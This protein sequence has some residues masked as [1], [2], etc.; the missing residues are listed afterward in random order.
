MPV[1]DPQALIDDR[2][3][4]IRRFHEHVG[5]D[6]AELDLSGG[7]DSATMLGLLSRALG[8]DK[9]VTVYSSIHSSTDSRDRAREVAAAFDVKLVEFDLT[10]IFDE[11]ILGMRAALLEAG[12][13]PDELD[14]RARKDPTILG[15]IRSCIRAPIG[16]GF[17]RMAGGGIRHGTGNECEDRWLRFFQKGG[18]GE[19][20]TN[21]IAMLAKGEVFQL[22]KALGVPRALI[23]ATPS[24]DLHGIGDAHNDEDEIRAMSGV[25]WT[26]SRIDYDSGEYTRVGT[27]E[28][29][30]RFLDDHP[31]L[32]RDADLPEQELERL[33]KLAE[34]LFGR[35]HAVVLTFL[36]S[37]RALEKMTRHKANPNCP[38]LGE[39]GPLVEAGVLGNELPKV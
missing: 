33:A 28:I 4:A 23:E 18:D 39:R 17:N 11:L 3:S 26:Y 38:S 20:D 36:E 13:D 9:I 5:T 19:V 1:L 32:L 12:H 21:P 7:I 30:S 35:S 29:L 31:E 10:R 37:A 14:A 22:A 24:P 25:D 27:I 16:R 2:V 34:P 6:R 15:S 8:P